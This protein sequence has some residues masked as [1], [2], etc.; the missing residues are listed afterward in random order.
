MFKERGISKDK[1]NAC[2]AQTISSKLKEEEPP[3]RPTK[4][5]ERLILKCI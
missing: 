3:D 1:K 5:T 4:G 2:Q